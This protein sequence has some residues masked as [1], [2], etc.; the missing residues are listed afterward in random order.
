VI[1]S[2]LGQLEP[3]DPSA[4]ARLA[5]H[6]LAFCDES[7]RTLVQKDFALCSS[8]QPSPEQEI[9]ALGVVLDAMAQSGLLKKR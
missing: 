9:H 4:R 1:A 6:L 7:L 8:H 3:D 2:L 5:P